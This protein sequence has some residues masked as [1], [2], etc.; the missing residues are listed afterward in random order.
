MIACIAPHGW[1]L[2]PFLGG[3]ASP[4]ASSSQAAMQEIGRRFASAR[5]DT[6]VV[7][8][9]HGLEVEGVFSLLDTPVVRGETGRDPSLSSSP[10]SFSLQFNIDQ[11]FNEALV[12]AA[13]AENIPAARVKNK[14]MEPLNLD[15][16]TTI[17]LWFTAAS[18]FPP[19]KIVVACAGSGLDWKI[20]PGFGASIRRAAE[21]L[22]RR[23]GF[24]ASADMGHA[25]DPNHRYGYDPASREFEQAVIA[26]IQ[27]NDLG[28]LLSYDEDWVKRAKTDA[29]GQLLTLYGM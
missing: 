15:F 6:L 8:T 9:P 25:H 22:G 29:Y 5:P 27:A 18:L 7:M 23:V 3:P 10:H 19:P 13:Q 11:E 28:R 14:T 12:K 26:A 21:S 17:P 24:I 16:A 1:L 2:L 4:K 20:F